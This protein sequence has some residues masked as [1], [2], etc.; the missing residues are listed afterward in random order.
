V[1]AG[2]LGIVLAF[3]ASIVAAIAYWYYYKKK[4]DNL[5]AIGNASYYIM[6]AGIVFAI[7]LMMSQIMSYNFQLNYVYS[8]SSLALPKHFV[9]STLWAGQE[10]TFLMWLTFACI[11]GAILVRKT[12]RKNPLVLF[13]IVLTQTYILLILLTRNPFQMIWEV[14]SDAP[15]GF[16]PADGRGLNPLLQNPWMRIHPPT[17]FLGYASTVVPFAFAMS[18][19]VRKD[20]SSWIK[21]AKSWILFTVLILGTGIIMGGYW[22]YTTLGWGGYWGWDPVENASLVPWLFAVVMLHGTMIQAKQKGLVR[23]NL[24]FAGLCYISMLWGSFLTRSGALG[25]FSV[26]SFAESDLNIYLICYVGLFALLFVGMYLY[27]TRSVKGAAFAEGI[28]NRESFILFGMMAFLFSGVFTFVGTSAPFFTAII[29]KPSGVNIEFYQTI[30]LPIALL[31][32]LA[33]S[34]APL[35]V[36]K[37]NEFRNKPRLV[38]SLIVSF[39]ITTAAMVFGLS[40]PIS[41]LLFFL[42]V[43]AIIINVLVVFQ[44]IRRKPGKMGGYLAHVG[45]GLM[46]IGIIT[47]EMYDTS[48]KMALPKGE[49]LVSSMGYEL[50][51]VGFK[52][53]PNGK[54]RAQLIVRRGGDEFPAEMNFYFSEYTN[55]YMISPYVK[56]EALR[57]VYFSPISFIPAEEGN[58]E[59]LALK[60]GESQKVGDVEVTFNNFEVEQHTGAGAMLVKANL[61]VSVPNGAYQ[62]SFDLQPVYKFQDGEFQSTVA[63]IPNR[64]LSLK[65]S[66]VNANAETVHLNLVSSNGDAANAVDYLGIEVSEKP[67]ISILWFGTLIAIFAVLLTLVDHA[68]KK[69]TA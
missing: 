65:I 58:S 63:Q 39:F 5:L 26:H 59:N 54:D 23:S 51:F 31:M 66:G 16:V 20:L 24:V 12:V 22:A 10:G 36:W 37:V 30:H 28:L 43:F 27:G 48:E 2:Y 55:G 8:Y 67:F 33:V 29:G 15:V 6:T 4:T 57:D 53:M 41:I 18:A 25:D 42:S 32:I 14:H 60:K 46:I 45:F 34:V 17:L 52:E 9:F 62:D 61:T 7:A 49:F 1:I 44:L 68:R 40:Q 64:D 35:L 3:S 50:K 21:E 47:S 19:M 69:K 11:F 13:F 38:K 56:L